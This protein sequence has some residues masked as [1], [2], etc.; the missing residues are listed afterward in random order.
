M[1]VERGRAETG[2]GS[3]RCA[4][5][6]VRWRKVASRRNTLIKDK[7]ERGKLRASISKSEAMLSIVS[8]VYRYGTRSGETL[9]IGN[10]AQG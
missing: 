1:L 4:I 7:K 3:C 10:E 6:A 5:N 8:G 9:V 2:C